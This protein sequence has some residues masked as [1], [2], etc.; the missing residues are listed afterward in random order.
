MTLGQWRGRPDEGDFM[1]L[2][3]RFSNQKFFL[4]CLFLTVTT[5]LLGQ[6][7]SNSSS[8][9]YFS[10]GTVSNIFPAT[11]SALAVYGSCA[12]T[13]NYTGA[14]F[15]LTRLSDLKTQTF[16]AQANGQPDLSTIQNF[17]SG[18]T[19]YVTKIYD[20]SGNSY[21]VSQTVLAN[22]PLL[23]LDRTSAGGC[24]PIVA[25]G[26][27]RSYVTGGLGPFIGNSTAN[28]IAFLGTGRFQGPLPPDLAPGMPILGVNIPAD[29]SIT[30]IDYVN[31]LLTLASPPTA[32]LSDA[33][34]TNPISWSKTAFGQSNMIFKGQTPSWLITG[35]IVSGTKMPPN[36]L[37]VAVSYQSASNT[38]T[39]TISTLL[40]QL[41][42]SLVFYD[43][44]TILPTAPF[45]TLGAN[46]QTNWD[47]SSNTVLTFSGPPPSWLVA[48]F[49]LVGQNVPVAQTVRSVQFA[50]NLTTIV[51]FSCQSKWA[52]FYRS[53]H[54]KGFYGSSRQLICTLQ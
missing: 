9:Q 49:G 13:T 38:T 31:N 28:G 29:D 4:A 11:S 54:A 21:H 26:S 22:A 6:A 2:R 34:T 43:P 30:S 36:S 20:Q 50:S 32:P 42:S 47:P 39:V 41:P 17:L 37:V 44:I 52:R 16:S 40:Q 19:G 51:P 45:Y 3:Q 48:G 18:T 23:D 5:I 1:R 35:M 33:L 7:C 14:L 25:D 15:D 24:P 12:V 8:G 46:I 10:Q 53:E 27:R